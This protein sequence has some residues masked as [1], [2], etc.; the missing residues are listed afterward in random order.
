MSNIKLVLGDSLEELDKLEENSVHSCVCDP[1]YHL[2]SNKNSYEQFY[3]EQPIDIFGE[4]ENG[5]EC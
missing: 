2:T 5:S 4:K 3:L 1:P